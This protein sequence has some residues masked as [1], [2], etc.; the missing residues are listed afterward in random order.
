MTTA[1]AD[2]TPVRLKP[3]TPSEC[4]LAESV[5]NC[6]VVTV[7]KGTTAEQ[8]LN[9]DLYCVV[10]HRFVPFDRIEA[11]SEDK[12]IYA[13]LV[14]LDACRGDANV[15]LLSFHQLPLGVADATGLP[16]GFEVFHAGPDSLWCVKRLKDG[17]IMGKDF[18][19]REDAVNHL[20]SHATMRG[21]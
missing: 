14:V 5:R 9:R 15:H 10:A 4:R 1:T 7:P 20:L 3:L 18:R 19:T 21:K 16:P 11:R 13:E 2:I 12:S 8:L 6:W 17:V